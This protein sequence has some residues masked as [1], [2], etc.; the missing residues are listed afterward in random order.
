M[1]L[2]RMMMKNVVDLK[3]IKATMLVGNNGSFVGFDNVYYGTLTPNPL[4]NG[5]FVT[6]CASQNGYIALKPTSIKY[7][8]INNFI[9]RN[10]YYEEQLTSYLRNNIGKQIQV[11]FHFD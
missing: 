1:G 10:N 6:H 5:V 7:C 2:N 3:N 11:I 9:V 8:T 4:P